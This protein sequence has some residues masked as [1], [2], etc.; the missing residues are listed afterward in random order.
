VAADR[1]EGVNPLAAEGRDQFIGAIALDLASIGKRFDPAE[2]IAAIGGAEDRATDVG[3]AAPFVA[4]ERN[5]SGAVVDPVEAAADADATP[6]V[7]EGRED[8]GA[9]DG[10][11]AGGVA[12]ARGDRDAHRAESYSLSF[13]D[14]SSRGPRTRPGR[15]GN[16]DGTSARIRAL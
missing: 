3:D 14:A 16:G 13:R 10:V 6:P 2:G 12:A 8:H 9:N 1:D 15:P 11:E 7:P 5:Q 4:A